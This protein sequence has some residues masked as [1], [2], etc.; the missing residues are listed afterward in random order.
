MTTGTVL[1]LPDFENR[2]PALRGALVNADD[3]AISITPAPGP[4]AALSARVCAAITA[5]APPAPLTILAFGSSALL[6]PA[7]ALAQ[8]S[9]HRRVA[10][11]LLVDPEVPPVTD[12]WPDAPVTAFLSAD[13][14]ETGGRARLHGWNVRPITSLEGWTPTD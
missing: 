13:Q 11:Y 7:I 8:R 10:E 4:A 14:D 1:V 5:A 2:H 6:L 3:H 12:G 9:A